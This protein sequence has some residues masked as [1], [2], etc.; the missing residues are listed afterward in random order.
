MDSRRLKKLG[1][2]LLFLVLTSCGGSDGGGG[3]GSATSNGRLNIVPENV[4]LS[5]GASKEVVFELSESQGLVNQVV[6]F[7]VSGSSIT[8]ATPTF[9][10]FSNAI[11]ASVSEPSVAH[12][13]PASCTLSSGSAQTSR[14][15][16]TVTGKATGSAQLIAHAEGYERD[17]ATLTVT[18]AN[19]YGMLSV[20]PSS[21]ASQSYFTGGQ[22]IPFS[23]TVQLSPTTGEQSI[24]QSNPLTVSMNQP[25]GN[26]F[27]FVAQQCALSTTSPTCS[28]TGTLDGTKAPTT[29]FTS[30]ISVVGAWQAAPLPFGPAD[31]MTIS[32]QGSSVQL[33]GT[34]SVSSQNNNNLIY[35]GMRAPLFVNLT[36]NSLTTS[37]YQVVITS[38]DPSTL[39]FYQFPDGVNDLTKINQYTMN[40]VTCN[41]SL[42]NTSIQSITNSI[43][44]CGYGMYPKKSGAV[45]L[46]VSVTGSSTPTTAAM[47]TYAS[48]VNLLVQDSSKIVTGRTITFTNNSATDTVVVSANS[49][50]AN[51]FTSAISIA[52]GG[53]TTNPAKSVAGAQSQCGPTNP[54][55]ACPIGSTCVQGGQSISAGN[56]TPFYCYWDAPQFTPNSQGTPANNISPKSSTSLFIPSWS[57]ISVG[58]Q[59]V[60]WS[61]NYYVIKCENGVCPA[62]PTTPGTG[63]SY[64]AQTL[65][66]VT[67]QHNA[68][69]FYDVSIINGVNYAIQFGPKSTEMTASTTDAYSCGTA[70]SMTA[71]SGTSTTNPNAYLPASSWAFSPK[72]TNF[73][74]G[75]SIT[76]SPSSYYAVVKSSLATA[77]ACT[78]QTDCSQTGSGGSQCGWNYATVNTGTSSFST[79]VCGTFYSWAT[80]NQIYGWNMTS[81]NSA[82][83]SLQKAFTV[84][85]AFNTQSTVSTGDLQLCVNNTYSSYTNPAPANQPDASVN[86]S[87]ALACGG[88]NWDGTTRP[89]VSYTTQNL[90]WVSYVLPTISWLK[91]ACPTCYTYPYDDMSATFTCEKGLNTQGS[92]MLDY[93]IMVNDISNT[94]N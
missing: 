73:P 36:G 51:A 87:S 5:K 57:G 69:D 82:P 55:N 21:A 22:L 64:A 90:K 72:A 28:I 59:Q 46:A 94:F 53:D 54:T 24:P 16:L 67:Y 23:I 62:S 48:T 11:A 74:S 13:T 10:L 44:N 75:T 63:S 42:D 20:T 29:N 70:G 60:Q 37:K 61:G 34:I 31:N 3:G 68:V 45:S 39:V 9:S 32:W 78:K 66:E 79:R 25:T 65:A 49:G 77:I 12:V 80:A 38:N 56:G 41:L 17:F 86:M 18:P 14:C 27:T 85:P 76:D 26:P 52:S 15:V 47:P 84:A 30:T 43:T 33:P 83:F 50:T 19:P 93:T 71:M 6:H 89:A 40:S 7:S 2:C 35:T 4:S 81:S 88:T 92:N 8:H 91:A 1:T 58:T